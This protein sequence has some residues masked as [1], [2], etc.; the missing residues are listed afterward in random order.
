M[1]FSPEA[2]RTSSALGSRS[3]G[4]RE[5]ENPYFAVGKNA[6]DVEDYQ[7]NFA[8][9]SSGGGFRHRRDFSRRA[10]GRFTTAPH[11]VMCKGL[12]ISASTA[13]VIR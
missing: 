11:I 12:H 5:R 3:A 8:G 1:T 10:Q 7:F 6:I 2:A 9:T 4:R 13:A